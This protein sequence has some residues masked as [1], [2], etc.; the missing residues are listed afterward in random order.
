MI[1]LTYELRCKY[2]N[3]YDSNPSIYLISNY[4]LILVGFTKLTGKPY[5]IVELRDPENPY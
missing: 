2:Y 5:E 3:K 1:E 4:D